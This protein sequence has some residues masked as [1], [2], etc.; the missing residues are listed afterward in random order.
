MTSFSLTRAAATLKDSSSSLARRSTSSSVLWI[1]AP[2]PEVAVV[3]D[4]V[5]G[6]VVHRGGGCL[7]LLGGA[8]GH[9]RRPANPGA[10]HRV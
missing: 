8:A 7:R 6:S 9:E 5:G 10:V 4:D 3:F 2:R 1:W